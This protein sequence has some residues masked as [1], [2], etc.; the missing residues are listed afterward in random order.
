MKISARLLFGIIISLLLTV[1]L[2][3]NVRALVVDGR[4][5]FLQSFYQGYPWSQELTE[6]IA[7]VLK[8]RPGVHYLHDYVD[9]SEL[10]EESYQRLLATLLSAKYHHVLPDVVIVSNSGA[11]DFVLKYRHEMFP[12]ATVVYCGLNMPWDRIMYN[13]PKLKGLATWPDMGG[14]LQLIMRL[15]PAL[16]T[17]YVIVDNSAEAGVLEGLFRREAGNIKFKILNCK[18]A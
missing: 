7:S 12:E 14:T 4:I 8:N 15:H 18:K 5:L 6:G 10:A 2:P 3:Q 11:L 9:T 16:D 1:V 13:A 17:L